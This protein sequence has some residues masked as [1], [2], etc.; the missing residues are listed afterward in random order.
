MSLPQAFPC[1]LLPGLQS[2][3]PGM[4]ILKH[5]RRVGTGGIRIGRSCRPARAFG[6]V[7]RSVDME[8]PLP[9]EFRI[10]V[11]S[12]SGGVPKARPLGLQRTRR[13]QSRRDG[14]P[15][16]ITQ[17]RRID[18]PPAAVD[19]RQV[20]RFAMKSSRPPFFEP[21]RAT[22]APEGLVLRVP[23]L[24]AFHSEMSEE[25]TGWVRISDASHI[26]AIRARGCISPPRKP[27]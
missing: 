21:R 10:P 22:S 14:L 24:V 7:N 1:S 4:R 2:A 19:E 25:G 9:S 15:A 8:C 16:S 20:P 18:P 27:A 17:S 11:P 6:L 3:I 26:S 5:S 13:A 23:Y 12:V